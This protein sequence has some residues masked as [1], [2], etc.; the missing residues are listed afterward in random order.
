[1]E[2]KKGRRGEK[3][4]FLLLMGGGVVCYGLIMD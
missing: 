1:M 2:E 3:G 4:F